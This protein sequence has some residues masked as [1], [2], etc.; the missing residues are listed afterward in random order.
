[1]KE[2]VIINNNK[3][4]KRFVRF[5]FYAIIKN[6]KSREKYKKHIIILKNKKVKLSKK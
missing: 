1:L 4:E 2:K 3:K 6:K 5:L